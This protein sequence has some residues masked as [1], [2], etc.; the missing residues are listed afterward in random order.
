M[1]ATN[2]QKEIIRQVRVAAPFAKITTFLLG[3][4]GNTVTVH[5]ARKHL[6]TEITYVSGRDTYDVKSHKI[7]TSRQIVKAAMA[8]KD[9]PLCKTTEF[10]DVYA[11]S[12]GNFIK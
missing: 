11:D 6:N 10:S 3:E 1:N 2:T 4:D 12:L 8:G 7:A 5:Q 9:I